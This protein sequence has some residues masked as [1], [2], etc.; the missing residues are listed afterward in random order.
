[1]KYLNNFQVNNSTSENSDCL[2][3]LSVSLN[4]SSDLWNTIGSHRLFTVNGL[5]RMKLIARIVS[6]CSD[7]GGGLGTISFGVTG[8]TGA[9]ISSS[10]K[11]ND[12]SA[13][14]LW[15]ATTSAV[16]Q[17]SYASMID[18]IVNN[19][20]VGITIATHAAVSGIINFNCLWYA[21]EPDSVVSPSYGGVL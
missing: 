8:S 5:V 19:V 17:I 11:I 12:L 9:F 21:F 13:G 6:D 16:K 14:E 10:C 1:M 3:Y 2:N 7:G 20:N 18:R 4:F 15:Y